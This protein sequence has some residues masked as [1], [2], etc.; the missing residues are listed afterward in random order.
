MGALNPISLRE[1]EGKSCLSETTNVFSVR[2]TMRG[3]RVTSIPLTYYYFL[4]LQPAKGDLRRWRKGQG[5]RESG[6]EE[7]MEIQASG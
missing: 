1:F 4:F 3:E 6:E 2:C 5:E 7:V